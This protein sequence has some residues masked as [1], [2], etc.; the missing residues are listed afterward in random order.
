MPFAWYLNSVEEKFGRLNGR[1]IELVRY[2]YEHDY[3]LFRIR[4]AI[5]QVLKNQ[6][7]IH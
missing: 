2:M 3:P 7:D 1:Q 6:T 4:E 5:E